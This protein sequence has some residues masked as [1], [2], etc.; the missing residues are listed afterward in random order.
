MDKESIRQL[1]HSRGIQVSDEHLAM[2]EA[3]AAK[4]QQM[5]AALDGAPPD[6]S[7]IGLIHALE[8]QNHD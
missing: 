7:D 2:L 5:R 1:L 4:M 3:Q 8:E 6:D